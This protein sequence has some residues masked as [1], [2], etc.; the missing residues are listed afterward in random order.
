LP[1]VTQAA[2][3]TYEYINTGSVAQTLPSV[4]QALAG[5]VPFNAAVA[6]TLPAVTQSVTGIVWTIGAIQQTIPAVTQ[7]A[8]GEATTL[9]SV[10][11]AQT[12]AAVTQSIEGTFKFNFTTSTIAQTLPSVEQQARWVREIT[13]ILV[14]AEPDIEFIWEPVVRERVYEVELYD[15]IYEEE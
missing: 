12:L 14:W 7:A 1:A 11:I 9:H 6:Q 8:I 10:A 3:A 15:L 5:S 4:S 2:E 13:E